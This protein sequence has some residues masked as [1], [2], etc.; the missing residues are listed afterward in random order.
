MVLASIVPG[1]FMLVSILAAAVIST[2]SPASLPPEKI[3]YL[4]EW[5]LS[6]VPDYEGSRYEGPVRLVP[7]PSPDFPP[8]LCF[9]ANFRNAFGGF[10]GWQ[11]YEIVESKSQGT[12]LARSSDCMT[13][14][15]VDQHD[16]APDLFPKG[17]TSAHGQ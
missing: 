12:V 10:Y 3:A 5:L 8:A 11:W 14:T 17:S 1:A 6:H 2:H 9:K 15:P 4:R 13:R 16:Y 7:M